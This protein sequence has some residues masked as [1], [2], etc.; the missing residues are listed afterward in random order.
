MPLI[1]IT[2]FSSHAGALRGRS[3]L[4]FG[5]VIVICISFDMTL[6]FQGKTPSASGLG[7]NFAF[8]VQ[9][10]FKWDYVIRKFIYHSAIE[11]FLA[12]SNVN[13]ISLHCRL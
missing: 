4:G 6:S 7:S 12:V 10:V 3:L 5:W 8:V 13:R 11:M 9:D 1:S 2:S